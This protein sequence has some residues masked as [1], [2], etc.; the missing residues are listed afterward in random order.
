MGRGSAGPQRTICWP[1]QSFENVQFD[2]GPNSSVLPT[3]TPL[4]SKNVNFSILTLKWSKL[5]GNLPKYVRSIRGIT[6]WVETSFEIALENVTSY[7]SLIHDSANPEKWSSSFP[8]PFR[9]RCNPNGGTKRVNSE[10]ESC[11]LVVRAVAAYAPL[12]SSKFRPFKGSFWGQN[13]HFLKKIGHSVLTSKC[14]E[15]H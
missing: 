1:F 6:I 10:R 2:F 14:T 9:S 15:T 4:R 7:L 8:A 5:C 13:G 11:G 12:A 3:E